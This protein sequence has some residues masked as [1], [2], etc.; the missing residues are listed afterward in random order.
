MRR[1]LAAAAL[2]VLVLVGGA[3]ATV[4]G[5]GPLAPRGAPASV[6][7]VAISRSTDES[8][9]PEIEAI[10]LAAGTRALFDAGE[11]I[12]ALALSPDRRT[13]HVAR[14]DGHLVSLDAVTGTQFADLDLGRQ[15]I[16]ALVPS[17]DGRLLSVLTVPD[18]RTTLTVIDL[19]RRTAR[20]PLVLGKRPTGGAALR[21][22]EL[23]VPFGDPFGL[24][25]AFVDPARGA[26]TATLTL[27]RGTLAPP[28]A[29]DLGAD[30][31][32]VVGFEPS[33]RAS[34]GANVYL[35]RD[36][37]HW[38]AVSAALPASLGG[39]PAGPGN[40]LLLGGGLQAA[41]G[42]GT[43]HLCASGPGARRYTVS[44]S[45]RTVAVAGAECGPLAGGSDVVLAR[46]D[47]AQLLVLDGRSG[48]NTRT[49]PLAGVPARLAR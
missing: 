23:I 8:D 45:D 39:R 33:A 14:A 31:V 43:L 38:E 11:R 16:A 17:A 18:L 2:L 32:A 36:A 21:G 35:V 10:D 26:V 5:I 6:V 25:V 37:T 34:A 1:L 4:A 19:E 47:P 30:G 9:A 27:P 7:F 40:P 15:P 28:L 3:A 42:P 29:V 44:A 12:S 49:L 20:T 48:R 13:L 22:G 41:S 46:R 24:D